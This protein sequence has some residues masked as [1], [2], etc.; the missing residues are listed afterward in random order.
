[1]LALCWGDS[2]PLTATPG[3]VFDDP[4][5]L[6]LQH[7]RIVLNGNTTFMGF[8]SSPGQQLSTR[9][10]G[11]QTVTSRGSSVD[12]VS[13]S[14]LLGPGLELSTG[15]SFIYPVLVFTTASNLLFDY[16]SHRSLGLQRTMASG[17][18]GKWPSFRIEVCKSYKSW[19]PG[20]EGNGDYGRCTRLLQSGERIVA[21]PNCIEGQGKEILEGINMGIHD[22]E[23]SPDPENVFIGDIDAPA[24]TYNL[25]V[26][27][28][29]SRAFDKAIPLFI[30]CLEIMTQTF[31]VNHLYV[32]D[33]HD[34]LGLTYATTGRNIEA[35]RHFRESLTIKMKSLSVG[36]PRL[37][38]TCE[39]L[40]EVY[41]RMGDFQEARKYFQRAFS[42]AENV[43][44]MD[45]PK[46]SQLLESIARTNHAMGLYT[47]AL[48]VYKS[49]REIRQR[50]FGQQGIET[51]DVSNNLAITYQALSAYDQALELLQLTLSIYEKQLGGDDARTA[52][53]INNIG[54]VYSEQGKFTKARGYFERALR[55]KQQ[56][57][58]KGHINT[59]DAL[60]NLS[61][62]YG[63]MGHVVKALLLFTQALD[64][65]KRFYGVCHV[66]TADMYGNVGRAWLS[67]GQTRVARE[68]IQRSRQILVTALGDEHP[69]SLMAEITLD[70][71]SFQER[72]IKKWRRKIH[73]RRRCRR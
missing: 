50:L 11:R 46:S 39:H 33:T 28:A 59:M 53:V 21:M 27:C 51:A 14:L 15:K 36:D 38:D 20:K 17:I 44:G 8:Y 16:V 3:Y 22:C 12:D 9:G 7:P 23:T 30:R 37:A 13:V 19:F 66:N 42:I 32:A 48:T 40:G 72:Q 10:S 70:T 58:G 45:H 56:I 6:R 18:M 24:R 5:S 1:M 63:S 25:A 41:F 69:K 54:V 26:Q 55:I 57:F 67:L 68:Y 64:I 34:G 62:T 2:D 49:V 73:K 52:D 65:T 47:E 35:E 43:S 71:V 60:N 4:T 61:V 31:G 29:K